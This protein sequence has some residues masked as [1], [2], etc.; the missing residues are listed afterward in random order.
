MLRRLLAWSLRRAASEQGLAPLVERLRAI[1]PDLSGQY[2]L[3]VE[4]DLYLETKIRAQHAFQCDLM[5]RALERLPPG[6][7][8]VVD[9]GD[10][11]GRHLHYLRELAGVRFDLET[12]GVNLDPIAVEKIRARGHRAVECRAETLDLEGQRIDLFLSFEMLEHLHDP[13]GFR[14]GWRWA[15]TAVSTSW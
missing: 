3:P 1:E 12:G 5:L 7:L 10:S 14:T 4:M 8:T 2:T 13:A 6:K 15:P 11:S 9:F